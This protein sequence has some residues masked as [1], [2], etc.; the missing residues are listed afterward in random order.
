MLASRSLLCPICAKLLTPS[1]CSAPSFAAP[2]SLPSRS[3]LS[4]AGRF[5]TSSLPSLNL[6]EGPLADLPDDPAINGILDSLPADTTAAECGAGACGPEGCNDAAF[7][8]CFAQKNVEKQAFAETYPQAVAAMTNLVKGELEE[9]QKFRGLYTKKAAAAAVHKAGMLK[10]LK[11]AKGKGKTAKLAAK[12][13]KGAKMAKHA[14]AL[15][16]GILADLPDEPYGPEGMLG[17][18][19]VDS[20]LEGELSV[21]PEE[22]NLLEGELGQYPVDTNLEGSVSLSVYVCCLSLCVVCMGVCECALCVLCAC[23]SVLC[24]HADAVRLCSLCCVDGR[25]HVCTYMGVC[26]CV[27]T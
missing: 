24:G 14:T 27:C 21:Y 7:F 26:L 3:P 23:A 9:E 25:L 20:N 18:F 6:M 22:A 13:P 4:M 19:P 11:G 8:A 10:Q 2:A 17:T 5:V 16:D 12:L 1:S 15:D